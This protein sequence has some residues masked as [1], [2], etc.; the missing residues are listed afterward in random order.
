MY[1]KTTRFLSEVRLELKRTTWPSW[2]EVRGTTV[3]VI[4][5][6]FV[7]AAYFYVV[8]LG[9]NWFILRIVRFFGAS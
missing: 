6:V 2:G 4:V 8:D 7:F 5:T 1:K 9:L 3:V